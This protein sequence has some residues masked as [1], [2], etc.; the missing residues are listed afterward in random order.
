ME[1]ICKKSCYPNANE[2]TYCVFS[3]G[4]IYE[5][6]VLENGHFLVHNT[7]SN[8]EFSNNKNFFYYFYDYFYDETKIIKKI[9][10]NK[11]LKLNKNIKNPD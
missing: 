10:K 3:E 6:Q 9:R 4:D 7:Y 1:T 8:Y 5:Y 2:K 11:I